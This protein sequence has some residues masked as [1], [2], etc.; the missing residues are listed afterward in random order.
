LLVL[1]FGDAGP[2]TQDF[3]DFHPSV[4]LDKSS[5]SI[6]AVLVYKPEFSHEMM[7]FG[8]A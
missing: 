6:C 1:E 5:R 8:S 4:G 7:S 3:H 2:E